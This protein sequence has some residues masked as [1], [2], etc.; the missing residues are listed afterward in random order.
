MP[1]LMCSRE[2]IDKVEA[3]QSLSNDELFNAQWEF[4]SVYL[5]QVLAF[6][7]TFWRPYQ[8]RIEL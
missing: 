5:C 4:D 7:F 6:L 1:L 2:Y 8:C 3:Y